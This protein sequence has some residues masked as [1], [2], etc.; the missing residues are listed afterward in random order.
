VLAIAVEHD[1]YP[2]LPR[3]LSS[4]FGTL[5]ESTNTENYR[6]LTLVDTSDTIVISFVDCT[7]EC[8]GKL[9]VDEEMKS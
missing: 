9:D 6:Y 8:F 4:W 1:I 2:L 3:S 7:K 5:S